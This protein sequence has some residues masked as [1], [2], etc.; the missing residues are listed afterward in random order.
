VTAKKVRENRLR[1]VAERRG[2]RL[3]KSRRRDPEALDYGGYM[4]IDSQTNAVILGGTPVGF[5]ATLEDVEA[6]FSEPRR[7][8]ATRRALRDRRG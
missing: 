4:L 3:L 2:Y 1:R 8:T 6:Y 5:S 7:R